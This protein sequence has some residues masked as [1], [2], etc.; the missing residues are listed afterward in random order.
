MGALGSGATDASRDLE[1]ARLHV[2][3]A[4]LQRDLLKM[5]TAYAYQDAILLCLARLYCVFVTR[6][7]WHTLSHVGCVRVSATSTRED[8]S[9]GG[10]QVTLRF[11]EMQVTRCFDNVPG[12]TVCVCVCVFV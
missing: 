4:D 11:Q 5:R 8:A 3:V 1:L 7:C 6:I 10:A 12:D 2:T 9:K